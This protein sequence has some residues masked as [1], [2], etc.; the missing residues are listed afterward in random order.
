MT[1]RPTTWLAAMVCAPALALAPPALAQPGTPHEVLADGLVGVLDLAVARDGTVYVSESL[2]GRLTE[3]STTGATRTVL[4]GPVGGVDATGRGTLTV[5]LSAP[6]E[7]GTDAQFS[8]ARVTPRG[9]LRE[10][11]SL[12]AHEEAQN[13][14]A[15]ASYG[16]LAAGQGCLDQ[17][18]PFGLGGYTGIVE[19]NP[20]G[21]LVDGG[22]RYVA[23]AAANSVVRVG[24]TGRTETVAVLPP[25]D[26]P[27]TE[28]IRQ[29]LLAQAPPGEELPPDTLLACV[30]ETYTAEPVPTDVE[31]GPDGALYVSSLPGFPEA[32]GTGAV[33]RVDPRTGSVQRLHDGFHGA[34]DLAVGADGEVY[35]AELF[36]GRLTRVDTSGEREH[37]E[38]PSPGA[39]EVGPDGS[40]YVSTGVFGPG[41]QLL[42]YDSWD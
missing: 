28:E 42:R 27:F 13:P 3:V 24:A 6:P 5:T 12:I 4:E 36:G 9:D 29:G 10:T 33:Y 22:S 16:F 35:V 34:V 15:G 39:V 37:V 26:V 7:A 19:S 11:G 30:G 32:P 20:F 2:V 40:V 8:V 1:P 18:A 41:G 21:V 23:D 17:A 25:L 38:L 31:R 14:D